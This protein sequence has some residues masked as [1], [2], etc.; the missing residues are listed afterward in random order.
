MSDMTKKRADDD[1][2]GGGNGNDMCEGWL[3]VK[4]RFGGQKQ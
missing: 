1:D 4:N 2:Y 3:L